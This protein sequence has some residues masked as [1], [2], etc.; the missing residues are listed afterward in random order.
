MCGLA[1]IGDMV[2]LRERCFA[3]GLERKGAGSQRLFP[4]K[5]QPTREGTAVRVVEEK[6]EAPWR[7]R[8]KE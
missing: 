8:E 3:S 7:R 6:K 2:A 5:G 1:E 4:L